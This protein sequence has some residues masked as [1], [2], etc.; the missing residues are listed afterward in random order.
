MEFVAYWKLKK[1]GFGGPPPRFPL[2]N[3]SDMKKNMNRSNIDSLGGSSSNIITHDIHSRAFPYFA[4]WQKSHGKV[5]IYWLGTEPFLYIAEPE[6]LKKMSSQVMG[7][8]WGKPAVFKFDRDPMFGNGLVMT[9]GDEWVRHRHVIAPA[10]NPI[11]LKV[12]ASLMVESTTK[13]LDNWTRSI[14]SGN[15]EIDVEKEITATAG[16]IIAR[17]SFGISYQYGKMVLEKLRAL[18]MTLFKSNRFVGVPF[19]KLLCPKQNLEAKRL[20]KEIDQLFFS[21]IADRKKSIKGDDKPPQDL[22]GLLLK[23]S[24]VEGGGLGKRLTNRELVDECKTFFFGGHETTALA[25]T[26]TLL[27]LAMHMDWQT[28]LR[29]E[30]REVIGEKDIDATL[31][32]GLKK[33]GW[34]LNEVLRLYP[35]A[36]NVQRQAR[37]DIQVENDL[38]IPDRTNVWIDVVAMHHDPNLWGEDVNE[39][40]PQRFKDDANGGCKH[41]MGYVP[42]GF[43]GRM[44]V[45]RNLTFMEYKIVLTLILSR[46]SF[47]LS[48]NY[49]HSPSILLSLRPTHGLPLIFHQL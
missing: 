11:N 38:T 14:N 6:F 9:E 1:N 28:Q 46:F 4:R 21:I 33:M 49:S 40:K 23:E 10:F 41:K 17:T 39:F 25:I 35:S 15:S 2:G 18:Q 5:F 24:Q 8:G 32:S 27:L 31:L 30:I 29:E 48:P 26:W 47:T 43:G 42:F 19:N 20:G 45:G 37:G 16:E 12:M 3:I 36:P 22:L 13:M 34:V 7:K 44:C